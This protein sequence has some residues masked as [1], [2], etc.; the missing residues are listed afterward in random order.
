MNSHSLLDSRRHSLFRLAPCRVLQ[1]YG[2][3]VEEVL[4]DFELFTIVRAIAVRCEVELPPGATMPRMHAPIPPIARGPPVQWPPACLAHLAHPA[5]SRLSVW[6]CGA[7]IRAEVAPKEPYKPKPK[8]RLQLPPQT[9]VPG[10]SPER[11][12]HT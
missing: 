11:V 2:L 1:H 10:E 8:R 6:S 3:I 9:V 12:K 4:L 5:S 7:E